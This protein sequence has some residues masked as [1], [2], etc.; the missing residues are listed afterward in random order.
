M[1][2]LAVGMVL[3]Y[4]AGVPFISGGFAGV[5]VFFVISGFVIT[6][7][8]LRELDQR[9]RIDLVA[10]YGR[11]AKRLLPA[12]GV[13]LLVTTVA[14]WL[15]VSRVRWGTIAV[16][17]QGAALYVVNWVF[18]DRAVDYLA[19][20]VEPSP[21][22]H[23]WSLAVEEQFYLIWPVIILGLAWIASR[24]TDGLTK[25]ASAPR[26]WTKRRAVLALGLLAL[27]VG[28]SLGWS[29]YLTQQ[30]PERAF[31]VTTTRLWE[32]GIGALV[33][34][35]M[36]QWHRLPPAAAAVLAWLGLITVVAGALLQDSSLDWPGTA[37]LVPTLGT[38][39][40]IVGGCSAA[41]WGPQLV[42]GR[43]WFVWVG[44]LSY[45]LYLWHWPVLRMAEWQWGPLGVWT[46]LG[47]VAASAVPAWLC[48][49]WVENPIRRSK[50]LNTSPRFALSVG[51]NSTLVAVM[52]G[53]LLSSAS[54][55]AVD[56]GANEANNVAE[57]SSTAFPADGGPPPAERPADSML[58]DAITPDPS[59]ATEDVPRRRECQ[60]D[61]EDEMLG[62]PCILGDTA[63]DVRVA[64]AGDSKMT[65]WTD[66]LD[67][68][69]RREG[70]RLEVYTK[71]GC[72][73]ANAMT[74]NEGVPY[75]TC[76]VWNEQ[77]FSSLRADPPDVLLTS[78]VRT[79]AGSPEPSAEA[80]RQGYVD[81]WKPLAERDTT[82]VALSDT[83]FATL[84]E[85]AY[86]CVADHPDDFAQ[87]CSWRYRTTGSSKLL[88]EALESVGE[89]GH[90]IDMDPWVCPGGTCVSVYR[91]ILT[92]RQGSHITATFTEV[93]TEP[94]DRKL[95][96]VVDGARGDKG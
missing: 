32:L 36:A 48:Y 57:R 46:G 29:V 86:E 9:G 96:P 43:A 40:V 33:A 81:F 47:L 80:L 11:R 78:A 61:R 75:E 54:A 91:N 49:T 83:P 26:G 58:A 67:T 85:P 94:L 2:A 68:I 82:I 15:M 92:Y 4:H 35:G 42:L 71:S 84:G 93:L 21:V 76:Q 34:I 12:A 27:V 18:A 10:F 38:A 56:P 95:T 65:Q 24:G 70:W 23:F 79:A 51:L 60:A 39:T 77:L 16:D 44:G 6:M 13:V 89:Q 90:Y 50:G 22:Q 3:L 8:L 31:F 45:S 55:S 88:Q 28:P 69:A 14:S 17:I 63:S 41:R 1:R 37:A 64:L 5:D 59:L 73:F 66:A 62:E 25:H 20:D 52:A 87:A 72:A 30:S 74:I 19:E 53:L 7:Q